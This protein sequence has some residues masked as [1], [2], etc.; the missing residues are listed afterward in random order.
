VA[1]KKIQNFDHPLETIDFAMF[2]KIGAN[3]FFPKRENYSSIQLNRKGN[4]KRRGEVETP[5]PPGPMR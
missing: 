4:K 1:E 5:P 2:Y 3:H